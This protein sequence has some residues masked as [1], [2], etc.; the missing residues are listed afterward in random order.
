MSADRSIYLKNHQLLLQLMERVGIASL[1]KLS[2]RS[3]ISELQLI[4]LQYGLMPKMPIEILLK[5]SQTLQVP[6]DKLLTLFCPEYL[7]PSNLKQE[8]DSA[9]RDALRQEYQRLQQQL[10][11]QRETIAREF[12][13][14]SLQRLEPWLL[15]WPTAASVAQQNHQ[16]PA[17]KLLPLMKPILDLLESWAVEAI[18]SVGDKVPYDPRWH[19]LMEGSA[20]PGE[21]VKVRYVGY[22]QG[23]KLLY[24]AKVSPAKEVEETGD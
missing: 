6:V 4:R 2:Q 5:L 11:Q 13:Q 18:A 21:M 15:Q 20:E 1:S 17:V 16:L 19:Q 9:S 22:R 24:R 12:Q 23:E 14:A 3:G 8:D 10:E 7:L